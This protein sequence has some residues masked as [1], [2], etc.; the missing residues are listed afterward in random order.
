MIV[1]VISEYQN[2]EILRKGF[3]EVRCYN[4][5]KYGYGYKYKY[6]Y[7][8]KYGSGYGYTQIALQRET[9]AIP[10]MPKGRGFLH[11]TGWSVN[12]IEDI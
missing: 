10:P 2:D 8:Y 7:G 6:G 1:L 12:G 9:G 3:L 11:N 5:H 4:K